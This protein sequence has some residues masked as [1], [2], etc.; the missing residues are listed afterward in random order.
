MKKIFF[1]GILLLLFSC[2]P[3]KV[4]I[5]NES[6]PQINIP[7]VTVKKLVKTNEPIPII[8]I[9]TLGMREVINLSFKT[10]GV[11]EGIFVNETERVNK[12]DIIAEIRSTEVDAKVLKV[13]H[14][15]RKVERD[16]IRIEKMYKDS[17]A[18]LKQVENLRTEKL[19]AEADL[20]VARF[21]QEYTKIIA[22]VNG[23][24][25]KK[26]SENNELIG[27]GVP[28]VQLSTNGQKGFILTTSLVDKDIIHVSIGDQA[29]ISFDAYPDKIFKGY[30]SKIADVADPKTG[31]F[32]IELSIKSS[33]K[34]IL[35]SGFV[36]KVIIYPSQQDP[37]YKI[38]M[39]ALVE[40][41]EKSASIYTVQNTGN[42]IIAKKT[43]VYPSYI[44]SD[45]FTTSSNQL[46]E[47]MEVVIDGAPFLKDGKEIKIIEIEKILV[48]D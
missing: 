8:A 7:S 23:K 30:I 12:G 44:G 34:L 5:T 22:P 28:V 47:G 26:F 45:F 25:L 11:I 9:G 2:N 43:K 39:N 17:A 16:F 37:Y 18:T 13:E 14:Y 41:H 29:D 21:N 6:D 38:N 15:L 10:G 42:R 48:L 27:A 24:I 35:K 1:F 19:L 32:K 3:N 33:K 20:K 36:G 40:G 4:D 46:M 31:T